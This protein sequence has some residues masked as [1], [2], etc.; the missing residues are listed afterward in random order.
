MN[1]L[2]QLQ[3]IAD[4]GLLILIW[5]VQLIIY[6]AF[7]YIEEVH[8]REWHTRYTAMIG[9]IVT[10]LMLLQA[11]LEGIFVLR[12]DISYQRILLLSIIWISTFSLSVPCHSKLNKGG[13]NTRVI[14]HLVSTNWIRTLCW[15]LLFL[16]PLILSNG[17]NV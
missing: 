7:H 13:K 12:Q 11:G 1:T 4:S 8:F 15:S 10:P 17:R 16:E 14:K 2:I 9:L 3:I 5:I 6:P